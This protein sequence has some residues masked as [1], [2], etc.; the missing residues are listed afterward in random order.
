MI[1]RD[2]HISS[3][4]CC[5]VL[6]FICGLKRAKE[7]PKYSWEPHHIF[8]TRCFRI[9]L[10]RVCK[11]SVVVIT[12]PRA[13]LKTCFHRN[14]QDLV[15]TILKTAGTSLEEL[16]SARRKMSWISS[17]VFRQRQR[18]YQKIRNLKRNS[19]ESTRQASNVCTILCIIVWI[20]SQ[21]LKINNQTLMTS[22]FAPDVS[23]SISRK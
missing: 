12:S 14:F 7:D 3:G 4:A 21:H 5:K 20:L 15:S 2:P 13:L 18:I 22:Y 8:V 16:G 6:Y 17:D 23:L 11:L 19:F 1:T 10:G 9:K